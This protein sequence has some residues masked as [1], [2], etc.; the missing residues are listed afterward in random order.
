LTRGEVNTI[1][2]ESFLITTTPGGPV[3]HVE[4]HID[5]G[6]EGSFLGGRD[7]QYLDRESHSAFKN[8]EDAV[9]ALY[10]ILL[11]AAGRYGIRR[12]QRGQW[13]N[14]GVHIKIQNAIHMTT[15][16]WQGIMGLIRYDDDCR[17]ITGVLR[18]DGRRLHVQTLFP[19]NNDRVLTRWGG[20]VDNLVEEGR[21][22]VAAFNG[23]TRVMTT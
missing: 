4:Q 16:S 18:L 7:D 17:A 3:G 23:N 2:R 20:T 15:S 9:S 11:S 10:M 14:I 12:L 6:L 1:L 8:E 22:M 13:S 21:Q 5:S 19:R